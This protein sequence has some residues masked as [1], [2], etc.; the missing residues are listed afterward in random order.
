MTPSHGGESKHD[1]QAK[2][3]FPIF[4]FNLAEFIS[5][6]VSYLPGCLSEIRLIQKC[7]LG[8]LF[9]FLFF[10][11]FS[12]FHFP[13]PPA[14]L[15][16]PCW[17]SKLCISITWPDG[18]IK[19]PLKSVEQN[20]RWYHFQLKKEHNSTVDFT[21]MS[22]DTDCGKLQSGVLSPLI[23]LIQCGAWV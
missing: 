15:C 8:L 12:L 4:C 21:Q 23:E 11:S 18:N 7:F 19:S 2:M 6:D 16:L 9:L 17:F 22:P 14:F 5:V 1:M 20:Y 10:L 3:E 13:L